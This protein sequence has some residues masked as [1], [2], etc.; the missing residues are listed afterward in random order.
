MKG[1][2]CFIF[3]KNL[4]H[5]SDF[6]NVKNRKNINVRFILKDKNGMIN[7]NTNKKSEYLKLVKNILLPCQ[8]LKIKDNKIKLNR[9]ELI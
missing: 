1:G 6:R 9:Y 7:I 3:T 4:Y 8:N 5:M 2:E